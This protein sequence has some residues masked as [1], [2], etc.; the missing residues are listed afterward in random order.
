MEKAS[1]YEVKMTCDEVYLPDVRAWVRLHPDLFIEAYP[2]R[3]VNNVYFDTCEIDCLMDNLIGTGRREKLRFRWYGD[4]YS[5]VQGTLELKRKSNQLGWKEHCPIPVTFDLTKTSWSILTQQMQ[6]QAND[7]FAV[8]LSY[9]NQPALINSYMREY[10][11]SM[12]RQVRVTLDYHQVAYEQISH[13]TPN[14]VI[15]AP[16]PSRVVV[17]VKADATLHRRVS[18]TLSSFP[19]QVERNSKY[20]NGV[21]D[22]LCFL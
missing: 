10:Y 22:S 5:T 2:P 9:L 20:V 12:D 1:R 11:E 15:Q 13:F 21:L 19:L 3:Q 6:E 8:W 14:L 18:N 7:T 16:V 4:D 17:E